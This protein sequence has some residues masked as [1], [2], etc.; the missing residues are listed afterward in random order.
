MA[1]E[2]GAGASA[3]DATVRIGPADKRSGEQIAS[4]EMR[5]AEDTVARLT[6]K[7]AKIEGHLQDIVLA[8]SEAEGVRDDA[9]AAYNAA[10][11]GK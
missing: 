1:Q 7:R 9:E 8:L 2:A 3:Y 6:R 4:D 10:K 5:I 11:G